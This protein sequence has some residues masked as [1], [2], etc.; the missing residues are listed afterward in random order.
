MAYDWES[1]RL[2]VVGPSAD[3]SSVAVMEVDPNT[4][5]GATRVAWPRSA[6]TTDRYEVAVGAHGAVY[7]G[8]VHTGAHR[9]L[10]LDA[11]G[12]VTGSDPLQNGGVQ[13]GTFVLGSMVARDDGTFFMVESGPDQAFRAHESR[14]MIPLAEPS[15][16][17]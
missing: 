13:V 2:T 16:W 11:S 17:L 12:D 9:V 1:E 7:I 10:R 14:D 3:G 6:G 4:G 8:V 15:A 5:A